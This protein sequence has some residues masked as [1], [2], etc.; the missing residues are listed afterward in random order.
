MKFFFYISLF[1]FLPSAYANFVFEKHSINEVLRHKK[2]AVDFEFNFI[3]TSK[4]KISITDISTTCGCTVAKPDKYS[5]GYNEKGVIKGTFSIGN[6]VGL[7]EK[8]IIVSTDNLGQSKIVLT[9][10]VHIPKIISITPSVLFWRLG[11]SQA[12]KTAKIEIEKSSNH[13]IKDIAFDSDAFKLTYEKKDAHN[14]LLSITPLETA[15]S[16]RS[17]AKIILEDENKDEKIYHLHMLI[18]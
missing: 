16:A 1:L 15:Q 14:C 3:N 5:Y 4:N 2:D 7:Q 9:I 10:S 18:K 11:D 17:S 13:K 8:Q 12:S 6:R